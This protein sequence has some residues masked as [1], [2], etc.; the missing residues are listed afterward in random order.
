M[1]MGVVL[2]GMVMGGI[3]VEVMV[4]MRVEEVMAELDG[5]ELDERA[6]V[7]DGMVNVDLKEVLAS[8]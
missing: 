2:V 4:G 1:E 5:V 8:R 6:L 3:M 7:M